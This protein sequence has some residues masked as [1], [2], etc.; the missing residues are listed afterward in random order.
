MRV[1]IAT[2]ASLG[3]LMIS[4]GCSQNTQTVRGQNAGVFQTSGGGAHLTGPQPGPVYYEGPAFDPAQGGFP[5]CPNA[6]YGG[7]CPGS[8]GTFGPN[9]WRPTH[10]HTWEYKAPKGL[11]YPPANQPPAVVQYP[12]YTVKGPS[13]F[14]MK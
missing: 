3:L 7:N 5:N 2:L 8:S 4:A 9:V 12:Y 1:T 6:I 11:S 14:F 10:H 13:D